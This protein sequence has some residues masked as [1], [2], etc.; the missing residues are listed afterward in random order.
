MPTHDLSKETPIDRAV[1]VESEADLDDDVEVDPRML[2]SSPAMQGEHVT[3]TGTLA[4]MPHRQAMELVESHG[5][6]GTIHVT[7]HTTMLVVGEEGW[8]LENDGGT[9]Q[10]LAH[11]VELINA[12]VPIRIVQESEWLRLLDLEHREADV[13]RLF[14]PAMLQQK[15]GI[16]VSVVRRW[17]RLG[18]IRPVQRVFRLPY[19]DF[20]EVAGVR[21]L[22]DMLESGVSRERIEASLVGMQHL[23]P[24]LDRPLA[25]LEILARDSLILIR[26]ERGLV[27]ARS[28]Q[29]FLD[30]E[31]AESSPVDPDL[32]EASESEPETLPMPQV[33]ETGAAE[34]AAWKTDDWFDHGCRLLGDD[35]AAAAL[36]AFRMAAMKCPDDPELHFYLAAALFRLGNMDGALERY[37]MAVELDHE[38]IEA[39]TQLGCVWHLKGDLDNALDA[40]NIALTSHGDYADAIYHKANV[41]GELDRLDEALVMW[42]RY[43]EFDADGPWADDARWRIETAEE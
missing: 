7:R 13:H 32:V 29:R 25:Q 12:G 42:R 15:L 39:W 34:Q 38:Y 4:S 17:E 2:A 40:F 43:L 19:F 33:A 21:R 1:D 27:E 28:G 16:P 26:D 14:T 5:G 31:V 30:F 24:G 36:E 10:K 9:S 23:F 3:F 11:A 6:E 41:L 20:Q 8:P 22:Q 37:H 18:L 35:D